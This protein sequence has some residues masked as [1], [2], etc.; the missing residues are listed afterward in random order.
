MCDRAH[1]HRLDFTRFKGWPRYSSKSLRSTA[2]Y[3]LTISGISFGPTLSIITMI[4]FCRPQAAPISARTHG[5]SFEYRLNRTRNSSHFSMFVRTESAIDCPTSN[6]PLVKEHADTPPAS[7]LDQPY[8]LLRN[9][10]ILVGMA[11]K[12]S[13]AFSGSALRH[14]VWE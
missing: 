5:R 3:G 7:I 14:V 10:A 9:P 1:I 13:I 6:V 4:G 12:Q 2:L 11:E 8:A